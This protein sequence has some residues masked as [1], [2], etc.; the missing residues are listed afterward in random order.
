MWCDLTRTFE[1]VDSESQYV[2]RLAAGLT[3]R[4]DL[5]SNDSGND[6]GSR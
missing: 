4:I 1:E 2:S 3:E 5:S 6:D